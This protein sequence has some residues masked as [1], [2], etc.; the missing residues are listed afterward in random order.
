[1]QEAAA[2]PPEDKLTLLL[3]ASTKDAAIMLRDHEE[4]FVQAVQ[5]VV[6]MGGCVEGAW[7]HSP[8]ARASAGE[9][10]V[11]GAEAGGEFSPWYMR[12][13]GKWRGA[14]PEELQLRHVSGRSSAPGPGLRVDPLSGAPVAGLRG[15]ALSG[16]PVA[17]LRGDAGSMLEPDSAHN[18]QFDAAAARFIYRRCQELGVRLVILSRWA[19][20]AC[21]VPRSLYDQMATQGSCI[22]WRLRT[23]QRY[24]LAAL[25]ARSHATD[26][27][28]RQSRPARCTSEWFL[29]TF[30]SA[31]GAELGK[32]RGADDSIWDLVDGFM[33]YDTVALMASIPELRRKYM[34]PVHVAGPHGVT[35]LVVGVSPQVGALNPFF[36]FMVGFTVTVFTQHN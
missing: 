27:A 29:N 33:Q 9:T 34:D 7:V 20:Y 21:K 15:D 1:M 18:N 3:I 36:P 16:A 22:G 23:E 5:E 31:K 35:H 24:N 32:A 8:Q 26:A 25:W 6:I 13:G 11:S 2:G 30:C 17:G 10:R 12:G 19:A 14:S 28:G 4:L